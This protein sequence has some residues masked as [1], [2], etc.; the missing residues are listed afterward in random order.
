MCTYVLAMTR[1]SGD[2]TDAEF[3]AS[4]AGVR[5]R[6]LVSREIQGVTTV[7]LIAGDDASL[8]TAFREHLERPA[9]DWVLQEGELEF[10]RVS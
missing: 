6:L 4:E 7:T 10:H 9:A 3:W 5:D 1:V 8:V 2:A